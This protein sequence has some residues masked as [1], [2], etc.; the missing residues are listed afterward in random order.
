MLEVL[1]VYLSAAITPGP[2]VLLIVRTAA[3]SRRAAVAAAAGVVAAGAVLATAATFGLG[4]LLARLPWVASG[5]R[6]VCGCYLVYLGAGIVA[7]ARTPPAA[8]EPVARAAEWVSFRRGLLTNVT[9]PK[10]AVFF[11]TVLT[12][13]LPPS[14]PVGW[15]AAAVAMIV[16]CSAIWHVTLALAFS[17]PSAQRVY[18]RARTAL[19]RVVGTLLAALGL[20]LVLG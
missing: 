15:R 10:A 16:V 9:N 14:V 6:L 12:G 3:G 20:R 18:G 17:T 7:S 2:N 1:A 11:G 8:I 19:S 5:M 13:L 4:A